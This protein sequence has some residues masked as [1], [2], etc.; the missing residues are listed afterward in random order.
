MGSVI[1]PAGA[2]S[3]ISA[4]SVI[5]DDN[6]PLK[7]DIVYDGG[8][9]ARDP[10]GAINAADDLQLLS[11]G[12]NHLLKP[13]ALTGDTSAAAILAARDAACLHALYPKAWPETVRGLLVHS[14]RWKKA[15]V[16]DAKIWEMKEPERRHLLRTVGYGVPH[17]AQA[18]FSAEQRV[19]LIYQDS[20][21]PYRLTADGEVVTFQYKRHA[22]PWPVQVLQELLNTEVTLRVTLSYFVDPNPGPRDVN[23]KYRYPGAALRFD[24][25]RAGESETQFAKRTSRLAELAPTDPKNVTPESGRWLIGRLMERGSVHHDIWKGTAADLAA[26]DSIHIFPT[27]GWWRFRKQHGKHDAIVRYSLIVTI[28]TPPQ[29]ADIYTPI[30]TAVAAMISSAVATV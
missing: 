5:W 18:S 28:E 17:F 22:L 7:P 3:P 19:T 27:T 16:N 2:L 1:A 13:L 24:L 14:A 20:L 21:Q 11:T 25:R 6:W 8:N 10:S 29:S 15:M 30:S 9:Y 23:N 26:R 12:H 4:T